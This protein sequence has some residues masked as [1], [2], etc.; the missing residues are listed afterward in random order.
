M[1]LLTYFVADLAFTSDTTIFDTTIGLFI[2]SKYLTGN[3]MSDCWVDSLAGT[4]L[5]S[6][7]CIWTKL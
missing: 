5:A 3:Q 4:L 7:T 1:N 6:H 2:L